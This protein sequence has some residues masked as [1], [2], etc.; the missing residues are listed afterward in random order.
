MRQLISLGETPENAE[1]FA[2]ITKS[3]WN[4]VNK[5]NPPPSITYNMTKAIKIIMRNTDEKTSEIIIE[6]LTP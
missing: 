6:I 2:A 5:S 1:D 3:F 4:I